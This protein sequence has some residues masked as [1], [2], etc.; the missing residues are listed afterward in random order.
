VYAQLL[1]AGKCAS[2]GHHWAA[3]LLI[4]DG[5]LPRTRSPTEQFLRVTAR[6]TLPA[7]GKSKSTSQGPPGTFPGERSSGKFAVQILHMCRIV[8]Q[9]RG[10]FDLVPLQIC[11]LTLGWRR[12]LMITR[13]EGCLK[14]D[15]CVAFPDWEFPGSSAFQSIASRAQAKRQSA[16]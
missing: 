15:T 13:R 4:L 14:P 3:K 12:L 16:P 8:K 7:D 9:E 2:F 5:S 1:Q 10:P 11:R 6:A